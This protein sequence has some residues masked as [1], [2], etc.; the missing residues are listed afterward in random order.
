[1][2]FVCFA[3]VEDVSWR[4]VQAIH[5]QPGPTFA[6]VVVPQPAAAANSANGATCKQFIRSLDQHSRQ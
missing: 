6:T 1:M 4:H 5:S 2:F 3:G